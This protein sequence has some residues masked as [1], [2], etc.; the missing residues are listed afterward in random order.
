KLEWAQNGNDYAMLI[1]DFGALERNSAT[2]KS[3]TTD[4][5]LQIRKFLERYF[6]SHE[7]Q[8]FS[9]LVRDARPTA[10]RYRD[11]WIIE[12]NGELYRRG[13]SGMVPVGLHG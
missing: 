11:N 8:Y 9:S 3:F 13:P 4:E 12:G 6:A 7:I 5:I 1:G 10:L 2:Y